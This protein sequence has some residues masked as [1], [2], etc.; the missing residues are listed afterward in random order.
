MEEVK[1][2]PGYSVGNYILEEMIGAGGFSTVYKARSI[3]P[4]PEYD[5]VIAVKVLHPRRLER[6]QIRRFIKE[7]KIAK[8]LKNEYI[9]KVFD[10]KIQE[11]NYFIFMEFLDGDLLKFIEN[12]KN[13]FNPENIKEVIT[14]AAR[15][16]YFIHRNKIIH[17]DVNPSNILLDFT[18]EKVKM[19]DF[20]LSR[21]NFVFNRE[22]KEGGTVE[23]IAPEILRGK[24]AS[25]KSDIYAFG[26]TVEKVYN[27]LNFSIP[28]SVRYIISVA[29]KEDPDERFESMEDI[30]YVLE[31]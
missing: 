7:A 12:K 2:R 14:K 9:V 5:S 22:K 17:K 20:G 3:D 23:Y 6:R 8:K 1:I 29:T 19:T 18:L 30:I 11:K 16:L 28:E 13:F 21:R 26:K 25:V 15:G 31:N 4:Q 27:K 24:R 10:L